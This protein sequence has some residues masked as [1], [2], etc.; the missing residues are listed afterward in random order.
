MHG[1]EFTTENTYYRTNG[2]RACRECHREW[3]RQRGSRGSEYW[4][5]VNA[6]RRTRHG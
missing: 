3:D 2:T 1:H 4:R 5:A 6:R